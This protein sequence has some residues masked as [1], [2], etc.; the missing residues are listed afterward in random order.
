[1]MAPL[2]VSRVDWHLAMERILCRNFAFLRIRWMLPQSARAGTRD[3]HSW[4]EVRFWFRRSAHGIQYADIADWRRWLGDLAAA[5]E[6]L[7]MHEIRA[8]DRLKPAIHAPTPPLTS[9]SLL[10]RPSS[11]LYPA[12]EQRL[13]GRSYQPA[14]QY[15]ARS[16]ERRRT[17]DPHVLSQMPQLAEDPADPA[18]KSG[19]A[20]GSGAGT[21]ELVIE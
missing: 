20:S 19:A 16:N 12:G 4:V 5:T 8:L 2:V 3:Q 1:M 6:A 13:D 15:R 10:I 9:R 11:A 17:V 21:G 14:A 7:R 18:G